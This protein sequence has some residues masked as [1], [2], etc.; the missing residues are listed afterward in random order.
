[1]EIPIKKLLIALG[2][3]FLLGVLFA[4]INGYYAMNNEEGQSL[5]II[6]YAL[7]LISLIVG[8]VIA[9]MLQQKTNWEG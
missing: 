4:V 6:I 7:S 1:M 3:V 5:P 9:I 8:G 2:M